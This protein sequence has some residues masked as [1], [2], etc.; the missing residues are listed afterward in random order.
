MLAIPGATIEKQ[1]SIRI[2]RREAL[3]HFFAERIVQVY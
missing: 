3:A 2:R 1:T